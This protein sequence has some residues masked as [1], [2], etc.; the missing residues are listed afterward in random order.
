MAGNIY[1]GF[2]HL[3]YHSRRIRRSRHRI[4]ISSSIKSDLSMSHS[5]LN[6][7]IIKSVRF[8]EEAPNLPT[9]ISFSICKWVLHSSDELFDSEFSASFLIC[10]GSALNLMK[11]LFPLL[12]ALYSPATELF[13]IRSSFLKQE[14]WHS[15]EFV[16]V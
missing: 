10:S 13:I 4:D 7:Q 15:N 12:P 16:T 1:P 5:S 8:P 11:E 9:R 2:V 6:G 3:K 14:L